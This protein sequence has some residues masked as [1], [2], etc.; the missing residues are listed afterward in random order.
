ML[1]PILQNELV[2]VGIAN[3]HQSFSCQQDVPFIDVLT[4]D[5][6]PALDIS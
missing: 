5:C 6:V 4:T 1:A 2:L 3:K